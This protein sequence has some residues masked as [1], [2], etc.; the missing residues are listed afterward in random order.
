MR[1]AL[2]ELVT[3]SSDLAMEL[4]PIVSRKLYEVVAVVAM[5]FRGYIFKVNEPQ[6]R[7][8][9]CFKA[10]RLLDECLVVQELSTCRQAL[11]AALP[12][13]VLDSTQTVPTRSLVGAIRRLTL[14][15]PCVLQW[16]RCQ[17]AIVL[18]CR[19]GSCWP[20]PPSWTPSGAATPR[21]LR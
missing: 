4:P 19:V 1:L 16:P 21:R 13:I 5:Q 2:D 3:A 12:W 6:V 10:S 20:S 11:E 14:G 17:T 9:P 15:R 8:T 18:R 7:R